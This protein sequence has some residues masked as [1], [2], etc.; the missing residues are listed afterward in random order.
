[1][2]RALREHTL[3]SCNPGKSPVSLARG[4]IPGSSNCRPGGLELVSRVKTVS[5]A[6]A[7]R[8]PVWL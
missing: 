7:C 3:L 4:G 2:P 1:M 6:T 5:H 8:N